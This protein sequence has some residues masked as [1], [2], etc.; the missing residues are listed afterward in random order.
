VS[1]EIK[2]IESPWN[3]TIRFIPGSGYRVVKIR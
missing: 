3:G 2:N 1:I